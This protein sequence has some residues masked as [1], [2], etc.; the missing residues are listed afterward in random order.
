MQDNQSTMKMIQNG[1]STALRT[2]H[3]NVKYFHLKEIIEKGEIKLQYLQTQ[4]MTADLLTKPIQ[5]NLFNRL[6]DALLN[7]V[8]NANEWT[9]GM[10]EENDIDEIIWWIKVERG[11]ELEE[12]ALESD[13]SFSCQQGWK[14]HP[15]MK[16][17]IRIFLMD[18]LASFSGN[19]IILII[20]TFFG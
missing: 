1:T 5:G 13:T 20:W 14:F 10:K 18:P 7:R 9:N 15:S 17:V 16:K 6:K 11:E 3:I 4:L 8:E 2:K 12:R 19:I